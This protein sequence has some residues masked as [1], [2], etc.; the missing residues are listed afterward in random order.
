M[1]Q[2]STS[3]DQVVLKIFPTETTCPVRLRIRVRCNS[4]LITHRPRKPLTKSCRADLLAAHSGEDFLIQGGPTISP[5]SVWLV[6]KVFQVHAEDRVRFS[7]QRP[8]TTSTSSRSGQLLTTLI[9][10]L[11]LL[12]LLPSSESESLVEGKNVII[13][14]ALSTARKCGK[15]DTRKHFS[16]SGLSTKPFPSQ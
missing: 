10:N 16:L 14:P 3:N 13:W 8:R 7:R 6:H 1:E 11:V 15:P 2:E 4:Q 5:Y 12:M 9:T